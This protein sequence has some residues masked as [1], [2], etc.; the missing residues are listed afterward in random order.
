MNKAKDDLDRKIDKITRRGPPKTTVFIVGGQGYYE[1]RRHIAEI[2]A[3][4]PV[5]GGAMDAD[6][7]LV[8]AFPA[9]VPNM[10]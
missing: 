7:N 2:R 3:A 8:P 9:W 4:A 1:L 6:G 10:P 5:V